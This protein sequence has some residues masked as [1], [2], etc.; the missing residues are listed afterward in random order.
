MADRDA[1]SQPEILGTL[2]IPPAWDP[3]ME[4]RYPFRLWVADVTLWA[5]STD[6]QPIQQAPAVA[7]RLG[8]AARAMA[9]ELPMDQLQNGAWLDLNDGRGV[10]QVSG[11]ML[12]LLML[13]RAFA[14]LQEE[15]SL[16]AIQELL[17]FRRR[18]GE[19][20][21]RLLV[22]FDVAR[23]RAVTMG[24]FTMAPRATRGCC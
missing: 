7:L 9:R 11:F 21:D 17:A 3:S 15:S 4:A 23:S 10:Q 2:K 8:G 22:R 16:R 18:D 6:L 5:A 19:T 24:N 12:L 20:V 13:S 1:W 14:P